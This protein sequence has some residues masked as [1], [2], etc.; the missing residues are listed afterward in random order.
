MLCRKT[1]MTNMD[2]ILGLI[3]GEAYSKFLSSKVTKNHVLPLI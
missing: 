1:L 2:G 3:Y